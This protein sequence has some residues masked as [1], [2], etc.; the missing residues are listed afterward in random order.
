MEI[1]QSLR[2]WHQDYLESSSPDTVYTRLAQIDYHALVL[3]LSQVYS[4]YGCWDSL[5]ISSLARENIK[6]HVGSILNFAVTI[7]AASSIPEL[8]LLFALRMAGVHATD[9]ALMLMV[10]ERLDTIYW[11]GFVVSRRIKLDL[12]E[13]WE[14]PRR[15]G[16]VSLVH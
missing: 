12:Q 1:S 3:F 16:C 11:K 5:T 8:L 9:D 7:Q 6:T 10:V 13:L 14:H 15:L 4:Y 2:R